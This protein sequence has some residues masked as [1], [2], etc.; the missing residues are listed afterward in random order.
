MIRGFEVTCIGKMPSSS[1]SDSLNL[2]AISPVIEAVKVFRVC[3]ENFL[4]RGGCNPLI[5]TQQMNGIELG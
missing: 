1:V 5:V 4:D 2:N 3:M